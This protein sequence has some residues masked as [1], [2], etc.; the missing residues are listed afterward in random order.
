[1]SPAPMPCVSFDH[2]IGGPI[3][4]GTREKNGGAVDGS[5]IGMSTVC[6]LTNA[7]T[8]L[9]CCAAVSS[10]ADGADGASLACIVMACTVMAGIDTAGIDMAGIDMAYTVMV[11]IVMAY[12]AMAYTVMAYIVMAYI[13]MAGIVTAYTGMAYIGMA[14]IV[15]AGMDGTSLDQ[16][17]I[18][19]FSRRSIEASSCAGLRIGIRTASR[20]A[21]TARH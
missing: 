14:Y 10:G 2:F 18:E 1:M 9:S 8:D 17:R 21:C 16:Q 19:I 20:W 3:T 12:T 6:A 13:L 4:F 5:G 7:A 15:M 11:Y